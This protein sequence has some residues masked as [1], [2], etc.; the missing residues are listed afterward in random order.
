M[1]EHIDMGDSARFIEVKTDVT[2]S[3]SSTH[4][5][6]K[7][8]KCAIELHRSDGRILKIAAL[9]LEALNAI[10]DQFIG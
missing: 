8:E 10:I 2:S 5:L 3:P 7:P 9:P 4:F 6:L 1:R